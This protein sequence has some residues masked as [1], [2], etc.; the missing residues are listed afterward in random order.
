MTI[1]INESSF[2]NAT[3]RQ[4]YA[5][6]EVVSLILKDSNETIF[7]KPDNF[8]MD[9][10]NT[11]SNWISIKHR[12]LFYSI[13]Q[14]ARCESTVN[15]FSAYNGDNRIL[16]K[17]CAIAFDFSHITVSIGSLDIWEGNKITGCFE[18]INGDNEVI[19][20]ECAELVNISNK[21]HD[22]KNMFIPISKLAK[23]ISSGVDF[24]QRKNDICPDFIFCGDTEAV[25]RKMSKDRLNALIRCLSNFDSMVHKD[26]SDSV[27][28]NPKINRHYVYKLPD[29]NDE[30]FY[31]HVDLIRSERIHYLQ[32]DNKIFIGYIGKHL[33]TKKF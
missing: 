2:N 11:V 33:P 25:L 26:S 24:L 20:D 9:I 22:V 7:V 13:F 6:L 14:R 5:F 30:F 1:V 15:D 10:Y 17:G 18:F 4:M 28:Q 32:K 27:K 3:E 8:S 23:Y 21:A 31:H 12:S 29:G 16:S 19:T